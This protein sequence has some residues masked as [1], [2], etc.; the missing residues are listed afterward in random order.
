MK[1]RVAFS[2]DEVQ[3][4]TIRASI[5]RGG[6]ATRK[7]CVTF[8]DRAVRDALDKAPEPKRKP[9][10]REK[11]D[12]SARPVVKVEDEQAATIAQRD[13]IAAIYRHKVPSY[14]TRKQLREQTLAVGRG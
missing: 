5:Q 14:E 4:R 11:G 6:K 1:V 2:F 7:E 10:K 12:P 9:V 13:R 3:L 8:I